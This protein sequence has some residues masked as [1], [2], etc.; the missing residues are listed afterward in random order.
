[1]RHLW[2][3]VLAGLL[4]A[5][6]SDP[7]R[8]VI[9]DPLKSGWP[10]ELVSLDFD[11]V[12]ADRL[13]I[14]RYGGQVRPVQ[15]QRLTLDGKPVARAWFIAAMPGGRDASGRLEL[16]FGL[17]SAASSL[18]IAENAST[19]EISNGIASI[20][21]WRDGVVAG[22]P[23]R[24]VP[25]WLAGCALG[26][27]HD[28]RAG[29]SGTTPVAT[30][31]VEIVERGPVFVDFR[32]SYVFKDNAVGGPGPVQPLVL[33]KNSHLW[34][35]GRAPR[36][37]VPLDRFHYQVQ[38]RVVA[39][40]PWIEVVE[41][42]RLPAGHGWRLSFG[43]AGEGEPAPQRPM[44]IDTVLWPRWFEYDR[45]G[46]NTDQLVFACKPRPEQQGRPFT[47]L[48]PV[49][50][51]A[52]AMAQEIWFT[53][54]GKAAPENR[55]APCVG[56]VTAFPSKW[57]NPYAQRPQVQ[58]AEGGR[59]WVVFPLTDGGDTGLHYGQRSW[60]LCLGARERF[61]DTGK[62]N[63]LVR[64]H[65]DWPLTVLANGRILDW[66]RDPAR[67]GPRIAVTRSRLDEV[68]TTIAS[69]PQGPLAKALAACRT[70][71]Q[72]LEKTLLDL[73]SREAE[74]AKTTKD[75][76]PAA[77]AAQVAL[78]SRIRTHERELAAPG[79]KVL[80]LIDGKPLALVAP[81]DPR[82]FLNRRASDDFLNPTSSQTR[83]LREALAAADLA[84]GGKPIGGPAQAVI[85]YITTDPDVWPG[86]LNGWHPGN[87]NFHTD[88]YQP[89]VYLA[90]M[91]ADHP[92]A[93]DW[94]ACGSR[95]YQEDLGRVFSAPD[96]VGYECPGYSG[97]S[98]NMQ[99]ALARTL[100][101]CGQDDL[102]DHLTLMT[103]SARWHRM[104]LTPPDPRLWQRRHEAPIGDTHR[105]FAGLGSGFADLAALHCRRDRNL[106]AEFLA[107]ARLAAPDLRP[108]DADAVLRLMDLDPDL[109][110]AD[111]ATLDWGSRTFVGFGAVLRHGFAT[112][113]ESFCTLKAGS[114]HGHYHNDDMSFHF[115]SD[116]TP[117]SLDFNCSYHPRGDH[118]ALHNSLT[119]G[120]DG[121]VKHNQRQVEV[122]AREQ[123]LG[124]ATVVAS[125]FR[126]EADVVVA[127]RVGAGLTL[128]PVDPHDAEFARGY[129]TR[130][131]D[132]L[133]HRRL[134][135]LVKHAPDSPLSDYLVIR[136]EIAGPEPGR[137]HCHLLA[138]SA[139]VEGNTVRAAGQW[140]HD[141]LLV[142]GGSSNQAPV[143]GRWFYGEEPV[144]TSV[145]RQ[146]GESEDAWASRTSDLVPS[147]P[148]PTKEAWQQIL[149][150][151]QGRALIPPPGWKQA[152]PYGEYQISVQQDVEAGGACLWVLIPYR[153]GGPVPT[154][155][156]L[157]G[158]GMRVSCAGITE[159]VH[160]SSQPTPTIGD[161]AVLV[162]E[163][164]VITLLGRQAL[165]NAVGSVPVGSNEE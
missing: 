135:C 96:G 32:I 92:H 151:S 163:G 140:S 114:A 145:L 95:N 37:T 98:L 83:R 6:D 38:V 124:R 60:A 111:P 144:P 59:A 105:W 36:E 76:D 94:L 9:L 68:R 137:I 112:P 133:A 11:P 58:V 153:R 71:R 26:D 126:P 80:D 158:T 17:G 12:L 54:G 93:A 61:D 51:Q 104:L 121:T 123:L 46:G 28:G 22:T 113:R 66:P 70:Y 49:W 67:S 122:A 35:S 27:R 127:E 90:A 55:A 128:S 42:S 25:H 125:A 41:R 78:R 147:G 18:K 139:T 165:P 19:W 3:L 102:L 138:R 5:G 88:K 74:L 134:L 97:Y 89:A 34:L 107:A 141:L 43:A 87:P 149:D 110:P 10:G 130:R 160:L 136:D 73:A 15:V 129:P 157:G 156:V 39:D 33:G 53:R 118:A 62:A 16:E 40:D 116:Q 100:I 56:V 75:G 86:W 115:Y 4:H 47:T 106:A 2:F 85:G 21:I 13:Q 82:V 45:F 146:D 148:A 29:F 99:L 63:A 154:V 101:H 142:R 31:A 108:D 64:R 131:T 44:A 50:I 119:F 103:A 1:M 77:K 7:L 120:R 69:M 48:Q 109:A 91:L 143:L 150:A 65:T 24:Q 14:V 30:V 117:I 20:S 155:E 81:P 161:P 84:C 57:V 159:E 152:W 162:R 23:L 72:E 8:R 79:W 164:R 52:G 132:R